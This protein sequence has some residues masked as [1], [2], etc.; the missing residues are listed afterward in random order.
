[1]KTRLLAVLGSGLLAAPSPAQGCFT[2]QLDLSGQ[3]TSVAPGAPAP[4][5]TLAPGDP[6]TGALIVA[7]DIPTLP[8]GAEGTTYFLDY[9]ISDIDL[10]GSLLVF[11]PSSP[12]YALNVVGTGPGSD[13]IEANV[14]LAG[15]GSFELAFAD[16]TGQTLPLSSILLG[17]GFDFLGGGG[18]AS[19]EL[20]DGQGTTFVTVDLATF[21]L[22]TCGLGHPF[23]TSLPNST[24]LVGK[25]VADGDPVAANNDIRLI[26]HDLPPHVFGYFLTSQTPVAS[27][28]PV[29]SGYLCIGGA[30]GRYADQIRNSGPGGEFEIT[31]DLTQTPTPTGPTAVLPGDTW[32]YQAWHRDV[33]NGQVTS[34]FTNGTAVTFF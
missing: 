28:I 21:R 22:L 17:H 5:D 32:H 3:V 6:L 33:V 34:N 30:Q 4:Y 1:M 25:M 26:A 7:I 29:A 24:G 9:Q 12:H 10:G 31:P 2:V 8:F 15:G 11:D 14:L 16:A 27:P 19:I 13:S 23:C 20:L 18:S